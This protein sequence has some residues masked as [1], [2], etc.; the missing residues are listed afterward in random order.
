M[1]LVLTI[2]VSYLIGSISFGILAGKLFRGIDIR[3]H[4][5]G[6]TGVTNVLRTLGKGPATAVLIG[7]V[8]KGMLAV[9]IGLQLGGLVYGMVAG[10]CVEVGHMYPAY[11][12]LKGGKGAATG[13]GVML[14][15]AP[16]VIAV[17][18]AVFILTIILT[19]YVSLGSIL[20]AVVCVMMTFVFGKPPILQLFVAVMACF[21]IYQHRANIVRLYRRQESKVSFGSK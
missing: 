16:D 3:K 11:H 8:C 18:I 15:L 9:W 2:F 21:V 19:R 17:G 1:E 4:G 5:S 20:G 6:N 7:D 10:F 14:M 12:G 13:F